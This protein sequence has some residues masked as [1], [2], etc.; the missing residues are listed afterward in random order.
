LSG[1]HGP[2]THHPQVFSPWLHSIIQKVLAGLFKPGSGSEL[3]ARLQQRP[4]YAMI[5]ER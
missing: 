3:P 1:V 5:R 4:L 2:P